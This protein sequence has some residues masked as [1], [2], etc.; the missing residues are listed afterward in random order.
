[1]NTSHIIP[2]SEDISNLNWFYSRFSAC[3][4]ALLKAYKKWDTRRDASVEIKTLQQ[5]CETAS[6][7][8]DRYRKGIAGDIKFDTSSG[9]YFPAFADDGKERFRIKV[10]MSRTA[11]IDI[12]AKNEREALAKAEEKASKGQLDNEF[13]FGLSC[14][15]V[16]RKE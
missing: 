2:S 5:K 8:F 7:S 10:T 13:D 11:I 1:M 4:N 16:S 3:H 6:K 9:E 15:N 12:S 14:E